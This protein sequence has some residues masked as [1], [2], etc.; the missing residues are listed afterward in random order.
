MSPTPNTSAVSADDAQGSSVAVWSI[1]DY[2]LEN[3]SQNSQN[4]KFSDRADKERDIGETAS[5]QHAKR[6]VRLLTGVSVHDHKARTVLT[7]SLAFP[8]F[9][10][11]P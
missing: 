6:V 7:R 5:C 11:L 1:G 4:Y 10:H 3:A 2:P 9:P 8:T